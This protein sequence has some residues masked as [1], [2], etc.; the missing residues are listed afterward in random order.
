MYTN[1]NKWDQAYAF[2]SKHMPET[3]VTL[4]YIKQA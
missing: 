4:L 1:N 3:E 2:A